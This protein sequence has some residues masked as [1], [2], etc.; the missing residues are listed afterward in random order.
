MS[1]SPRSENYRNSIRLIRER[2]R[3]RDFLRRDPEAA[4]AQRAAAHDRIDA[5]SAELKVLCGGT[6][7]AV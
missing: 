1:K 2:V 6:K 7:V 3:L 4:A 5:I